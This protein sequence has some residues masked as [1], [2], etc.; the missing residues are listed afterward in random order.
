[1]YFQ[2]KKYFKNQYLS[3]S[4]TGI[5]TTCLNLNHEKHNYLTRVNGLT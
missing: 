4:Q 5:L 3:C 1:M 2:T